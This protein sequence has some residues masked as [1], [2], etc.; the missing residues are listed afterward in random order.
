M[1]AAEGAL[2]CL[3]LLV[4]IEHWDKCLV[5]WAGGVRMRVLLARKG[6]KQ[7][8]IWAAGHFA[9]VAFCHTLIVEADATGATNSSG[10]G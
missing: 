5:L 4:Q 3:R 6:C 9:R 7:V 8:V 2:S 10:N 1:K